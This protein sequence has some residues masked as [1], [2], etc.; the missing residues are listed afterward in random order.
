MTS[1]LASF[2]FSGERREDDERERRR[3]HTRVLGGIP[4][5]SRREKEDGGREE[6]KRVTANAQST[7]E[8]LEQFERKSTLLLP[9]SLYVT[10][11]HSPILTGNSSSI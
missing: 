11:F 4:R 9:A 8:L 5:T 6:N 10:A 2:P 7:I 3:Q 1:F